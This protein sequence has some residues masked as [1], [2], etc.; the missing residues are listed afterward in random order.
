MKQW[1]T[2]GMSVH[3]SLG[4]PCSSLC[5]PLL[6]YRKRL[7]LLFSFGLC[8][9]LKIH[10]SESRSQAQAVPAL[11]LLGAQDSGALL[12]SWAGGLLTLPPSWP[13]EGKSSLLLGPWRGMEERGWVQF[14]ALLSD[15]RPHFGPPCHCLGA[16]VPRCSAW[17]E[18]EHCPGPPL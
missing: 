5:V 2:A 11:A 3:L 13:R 12:E 17:A 18:S 15:P 16:S 4:L 9:Y 1:H 10:I 6:K 14:L 7:A 8:V